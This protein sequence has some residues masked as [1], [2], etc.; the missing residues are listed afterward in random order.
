MAGL[1]TTLEIA[2][3]TLLNEQVL[4]QTTSHNISNAENKAYARQKANLV[5]NPAYRTQAGW[6]GLG[7]RVDQVFQVRDQYVEQQLMTGIAQQSDYSTRSGFLE[8]IGTYLKD[9]GATGISNDLGKFWDAWDALGQNSGGI[10]ERQGVISAAETLADKLQVSQASLTA[11]RQNIQSQTGYTV[12]KINDL[13]N[14]IASYNKSISSFEA[15]GKPA[16]DLRD[17]RYQALTDLSELIGFSYTEEANGSISISLQDGSTSVSLLSDQNAGKLLYDQGTG[18]VSYQDPAGNSIAPASND[19]SGGKLAGLLASSQ[20][21]TDFSN[22]LDILAAEL[23]VQVNTIYDP[24]LVQKVFDGTAA[25]D[26]AVN[27]AFKDPASIN[28]EPALDIADLQN[29][30]LTNLGNSR[31]IDY[32]GDIQQQIGLDQQ[33][34]SSRADFQGALVEHLE[35]QQQSVS[36]VSIDEEMIELLKHQQVYQAA[37]KIV[38]TTQRLLDAVIGMVG[39]FG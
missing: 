20:K 18:L 32:L 38:N 16:N 4:I 8:S 21:T 10:V 34:A 2:K 27:A 35:T 23:I 31:F 14:K 13:L 36:G 7:A 17:L 6:L 24:T 25:S 11:L 19:L 30:Q 5:T 28:A 37:A 29:T 1:S 39:T 22:R 12:T 9:D 15:S 26:I 3:S 33:D